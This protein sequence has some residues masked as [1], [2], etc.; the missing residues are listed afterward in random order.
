[1][2]TEFPALIITVLKRSSINTEPYE[3]SRIFIYMLTT[4]PLYLI[5]YENSYA[6]VQTQSER[7]VITSIKDWWETHKPFADLQPTFIS[8]YY[9]EYKDVTEQNEVIVNFSP[10]LDIFKELESYL[11]D[12]FRGGNNGEK[13]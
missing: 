6:L 7:E 13:H 4:T 5:S 1:M 11:P 10:L 9:R 2:K 3:T 12:F 8:D